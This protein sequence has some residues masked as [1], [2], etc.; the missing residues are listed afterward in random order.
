MTTLGAVFLPQK[1]PERVREVARI[2]EEVG[3]EELWFWEDCFFEGGVSAAA[4]AGPGAP[5]G[6]G[7]G[8]GG[9]AV[10]RRKFGVTANVIAPRGRG[11][12]A[13]PAGQD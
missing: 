4:G 13:L 12:V 8:V 2:A 7:G 1:P 3:L 10:A 6:R 9:V 11:T 5:A